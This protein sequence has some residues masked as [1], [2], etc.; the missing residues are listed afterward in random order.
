MNI[1]STDT[2]LRVF[3]LKDDSSYQSYNRVFAFACNAKRFAIVTL[4]FCSCFFLLVVFSGWTG[5]SVL[6]N[7]LQLFLYTCVTKI[8]SSTLDTPTSYCV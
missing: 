3:Y 1:C 8:K 4:V 5:K 6:S 2:H 7:S